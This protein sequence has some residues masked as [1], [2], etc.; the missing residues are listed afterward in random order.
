MSIG[1]HQAQTRTERLIQAMERQTD[2]MERLIEALT[3]AGRAKP[4]DGL[5]ETPKG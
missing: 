3:T 4:A 1:K 2:A 5:T